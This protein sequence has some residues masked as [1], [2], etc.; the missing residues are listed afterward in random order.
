MKKANK[1][2]KTIIDS[3]VWISFLI[4]K[5]L[6]GLQN[7]I[8]TKIVQILTCEEQVIE[9]SEV[10]NR[11]KLQK[12]FDK[13]Q[14]SEFFELLEECSEL[15]SLSTKSKLCRDPK[16]NYLVSLAIDS[17]ADYLITGDNDLLELNPIGKTI[18]IKYSDF[19]TSFNS[20]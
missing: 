6:R 18:V 12:Y 8:D 15:V 16:D 7:F 19:N 13:N 10:F 14:I 3:N 4:G 20:L 1:S 2:Y 5:D 17:Q 9:L 11:P